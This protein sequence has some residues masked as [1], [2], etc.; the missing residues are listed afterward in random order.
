[1]FEPLIPTKWVALGIIAVLLVAFIFL[2]GV[3]IGSHRGH[4]GSEEGRPPFSAFGIF[5]PHAYI[6]HGHGAVGDVSSV[7][8]SSLTL[9]ERE[10]DTVTVNIASTTTIETHRGTTT[11]SSFAVGTHVIVI[12]EPEATGNIAARFIRVLPQP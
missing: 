3:G 6:V 4:F 5:L 8:T 9:T 11:L 7:A 12:G 2:A 1:M 10:G